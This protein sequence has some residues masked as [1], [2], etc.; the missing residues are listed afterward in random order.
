MVWAAVVGVFYHINYMKGKGLNVME[1][2]A[3][4]S[5]ETELKMVLQKSPPDVET[6]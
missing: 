1:R 6:I 4:F 3:L 2:H 5:V